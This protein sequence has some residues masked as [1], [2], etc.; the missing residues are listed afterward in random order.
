MWG[1]L[2]TVSSESSTSTSWPVVGK[3]KL[4]SYQ[5]Y[6]KAE[7]AVVSNAVLYPPGIAVQRCM[8][9]AMP[10][11]QPWIQVVCAPGCALS[12]YWT[13]S[14]WGWP[15]WCCVSTTMHTTSVLCICELAYQPLPPLYAIF[16]PRGCS[17]VSRTPVAG[18]AYV[19]TTH[20]HPNYSN[21]GFLSVRNDQG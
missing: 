18:E 19:V 9:H 12:Y 15:T 20:P 7:G 3:V 8:P 6:F 5:F 21:R 11:A 1:V 14:G 10:R 4:S 16:Y 2:D 17:D 13:L